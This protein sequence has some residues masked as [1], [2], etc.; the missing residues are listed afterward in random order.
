MMA[1]ENKWPGCVE[2]QGWASEATAAGE[3]NGKKMEENQEEE[4]VIKEN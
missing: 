4:A 3:V 2:F 1:V